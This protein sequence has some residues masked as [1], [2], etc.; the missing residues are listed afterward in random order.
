MVLCIRCRLEKIKQ[1]T[2]VDYSIIVGASAGWGRVG[3][4]DPPL[5]LVVLCERAGLRARAKLM[6]LHPHPLSGPG[7]NRWFLFFLADLWQ[8]HKRPLLWHEAKRLR[9]LLARAGEGGENRG[10]LRRGRAECGGEPREWNKEPAED[11][12]EQSIFNPTTTLPKNY[13]QIKISA[14]NLWQFNG[15]C[16]RG[17][18]REHVISGFWWLIVNCVNIH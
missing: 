17:A 7:L 10:E 2:T 11:N 18:C 13:P 6:Y 15:S 1:E 16:E 5:G 14:K 8:S 12:N 4:Q 9:P 3:E